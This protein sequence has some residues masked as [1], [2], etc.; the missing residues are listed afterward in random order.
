MITI[1]QNGDMVKQTRT[2][3]GYYFFSQFSCRWLKV[4]CHMKPHVERA[5]RD[6][7]NARLRA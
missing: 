7:T 3:R 4:A 1:F 2:I 5:I 6:F